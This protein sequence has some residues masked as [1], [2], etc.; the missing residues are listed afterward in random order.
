MDEG[1]TTIHGDMDADGNLG[2]RNKSQKDAVYCLL[3]EIHKQEKIYNDCL[4]GKS[5]SNGG[6]CREKGQGRQ[7]TASVCTGRCL[8]GYLL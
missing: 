8:P 4:G 7:A 1:T 3:Y 5:L 2:G 6:N